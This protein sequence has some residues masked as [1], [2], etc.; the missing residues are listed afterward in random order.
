MLL[1]LPHAAQE[2]QHAV[3]SIHAKFGVA[4]KGDVHEIVPPL[5]HC[6]E[7][8]VRRHQEECALQRAQ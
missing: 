4:V 8:T 6:L 5:V 1:D 7:A 2:L 3:E